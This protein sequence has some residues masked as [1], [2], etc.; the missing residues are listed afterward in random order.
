MDT[1]TKVKAGLV[2]LAGV[3][4]G[5][6]FLVGPA[7]SADLTQQVTPELIGRPFPT[8]RGTSLDDKPWTIP[9]DLLALPE[10][11]GRPVLL[12]I[13]YKQDAQFDIDRWMVG[14]MQIKTPVSFYEVPTIDGMAV[15]AF[16][17]AIDDGMRRGIPA[18][19]WGVV[20]TVYREAGRITDFT[21]TQNGNNARVVLV[22]QDGAVAWF[23]DRGFSPQ[24]LF[25]LDAAVRAVRPV[26]VGEAGGGGP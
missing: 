16:G 1:R 23:H 19:N 22:G 5:L 21:G 9:G 12:L 17:N 18:E 4:L 26:N 20:I 2:M 10:N 13:G 7:C 24:A 6:W 11:Q 3:G 8:V 25:A 15:S 14:L